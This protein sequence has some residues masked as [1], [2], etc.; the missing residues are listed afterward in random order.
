MTERKA[1]QEALLESERRFRLLVEGVTDYALFML[2]PN[3]IVTSW[4]A[5]AERITGYAAEDIIG[6]HFS[7]FY[8]ATDK[9]AAVPVRALQTAATDGRFEAEG[10][11]VRKD[12]TTSWANV[13]IDPI[14]DEDGRLIGYSKITRDITE[15]RE[16]QPNFLFG[17]TEWSAVTTPYCA[18]AEH[19]DRYF[20]IAAQGCG[21]LDW[22]AFGLLAAWNAGSS[23]GPRRINR[24]NN[25]KG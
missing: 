1:A 20:D 22:S 3:G 25:R 12:G 2:D 23:I 24:R 6:H 9:A 11:R 17:Q 5:G 8:T 21:D 19:R 15:R 18:W 10:W 16:A 7:R 14:R 4:N 13:V